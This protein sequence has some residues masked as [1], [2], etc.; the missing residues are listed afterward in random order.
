MTGSWVGTRPMVLGQVA[1]SSVANMTLLLIILLG[2]IALIV[3]VGMPILVAIRFE[4]RRKEMEHLERMRAIELGRPL[5]DESG[6][7]TPAR[8]AV[9]I[10]MGVPIGVFAIGVIAAGTSGA[11]PFIWPAAGAVGVAA[12]ICGTVLAVRLPSAA[13]LTAD[14]SVKPHIHPDTYDAA[15]HQ[16]A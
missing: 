3:V 14:P 1:D 12:V 6:W 13:S 15:E 9:G 16:H 5:A 4:A 11:A 10:G 2:V 7:W 8:M